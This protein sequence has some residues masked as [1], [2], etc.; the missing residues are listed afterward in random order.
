[1][2][3]VRLFDLPVASG[4]LNDLVQHIHQAILHRRQLFQVSLNASKITAIQTNS[5]LADSVKD[6]DLLTADGHSVVLA[7][8]LL[9]V[10]LPARVPGIDLFQQLMKLAHQKGYK[11]YL[12]GAKPHIVEQLA[13]NFKQAYHPQVIAGYHHGYFTPEEEDHIVQEINQSGAQMLFVGMTSPRKELFL[14]RNRQRL[15]RLNLIMGVGG[16]FDVFAGKVQRA[17]QWMQQ[18]GLE[19]FFRFIQE[20]QRLWKRYLTTNLSFFGLTFSHFYHQQSPGWRNWWGFG[21]GYVDRGKRR[22]DLLLSSL[23]IVLVFPWL[24]PILALAVKISSPGPVFFKQVRTGRNGKTFNCYKFR[25]MRVNG[26][27]DT[28]QARA[29]DE[30]ITRIGYFLRRSFLD[31]TP[32]LLNV[33]GGSMS[34]IGPR[35]HMLKHTQDYSRLI[36]HYRQRLTTKPGITGLAQIMGFFGSTE[37]L[38]LMKARIKYDLA[39]NQQLDLEMDLRI[40]GNTF[41]LI[42]SEGLSAIG[43]FKTTSKAEK[44]MEMPF[45][46]TDWEARK[47]TAPVLKYEALNQAS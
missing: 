7:S 27:A 47:T 2:K 33:F 25:T 41:Q 24:F 44:A 1:M 28:R 39:Y 15:Q 42:F 46:I 3:T 45:L 16:S 19:W 14:K 43:L 11:V 18:N 21:K 13:A 29:N 9:G 38:P 32:Q 30:R 31:E 5:L 40:I 20:P 10:P 34:I 26:E 12:L 17:P 8:R 35:P 37:T 22:I 23:A 4:N 6:A 36:P